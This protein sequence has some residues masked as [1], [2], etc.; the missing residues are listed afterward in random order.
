MRCAVVVLMIFLHTSLSWGQTYTI[1]NPGFETEVLADGVSSTLVPSWT[2][3]GAS[4]TLNP[5]VAMLPGEA[6]EGQNVWSVSGVSTFITQGLGI[7]QPGT[8]TLQGKVGLISGSV[9]NGLNFSLRGT[10]TFLVE[11]SFS[12]PIPVPGTMEDWSITYVVLPTNANASTIGSNLNIL[13]LSGAT[14]GT[15][16][17]LDDV[18]ISF[19]AVP[20]PATYVLVTFTL[21]TGLGVERARRRFIHRLHESSEV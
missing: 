14:S 11:S 9:F 3:I 18:R 15:S 20:E 21:L 12:R 19:V 6:P 5:T 16:A 17:V 4:V 7:L 2:K 1:L 8:Y 13:A 10:N